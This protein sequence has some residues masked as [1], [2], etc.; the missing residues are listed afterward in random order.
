MRILL[1][2]LASCVLATAAPFGFNANQMVARTNLVGWWTMNSTNLDGTVSDSSGGGK[3]G[4][5]TGTPVWS[6]GVVAG[7]LFGDGTNNVLTV[8]NF[9]YNTS[10][11]S[12]FTW[13]KSTARG[14]NIL[15]CSIYGWTLQQAAIGWSAQG[16]ELG[17]VVSSAASPSSGV[18]KIYWTSGVNIADG[19]WHIVGFTFST[20]VLILYVDGT[21]RGVIKVWDGTVNAINQSPVN[22]LDFVNADD[23]VR[24]FNRALTAAEVA[25][26]CYTTNGVTY[27]VPG[28]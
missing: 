1:T 2:L 18:T 11:L 6:G 15:N 9:T 25:S 19:K 14:Q 4:V 28:K 13:T 26:M 16:Y 12:V 27:P 3:S 17:V 10:A 5:I 24:I 23:D 8:T 20:N 21:A 7:A 22:V